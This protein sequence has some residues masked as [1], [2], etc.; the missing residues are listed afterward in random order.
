MGLGLCAPIA[1]PLVMSA[2]APA[3]EEAAHV[4]GLEDEEAT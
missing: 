2:A 3:A 1:V 4:A